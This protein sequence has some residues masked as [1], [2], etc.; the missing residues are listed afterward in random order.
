MS[1]RSN[2]YGSGKFG[3]KLFEELSVDFPVLREGKMSRGKLF[4]ELFVDFPVGFGL[5][6][7]VGSRGGCGGRW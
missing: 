7:R 5:G 2:F 4:E 1:Q 6:W 3:G